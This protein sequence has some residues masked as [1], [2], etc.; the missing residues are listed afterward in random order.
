MDTKGEKL[1]LKEYLPEII[2]TGSGKQC[3]LSYYADDLYISVSYQT[4]QTNNAK[5]E[6]SFTFPRFISKSEETF[7]VL[8]LLQAEMGKTQNGCL[9]FTNSEPK[10]MNKV[11]KWFYKELDIKTEQWKWYLAA[12]IQKPQDLENKRR[13]EEY[14]AIYWTKNTPLLLANTH[15]TLVS[16]RDVEHLSLKSAYYGVM[17]IEFKNNLFSQIFKNVLRII[18][19]E[20][21]LQQ[22]I[23]FIRSFLK[24]LTAGEGCIECD[25]DSKKFRVHISCTIPAEKEIYIKCLAKLNINAYDYPG[26]KITVSRRENLVQLL[27]QRLMTLH[28]RKYAAFLNMMKHYPSISQQTGYFTGEK[29]VWNKHPEEINQ[30]ILKLFNQGITR[31]KDIAEQLEISTIKVNRILKKNNL[32]KR[33]IKTSETIRKE[34]ADY[35]QQH[36]ELSLKEIGEHF[37]LSE[38]AVVRACKKYN[39]KRDPGKLHCTIP[40]EKIQRIIQLYKDDPTIKFKQIMQEV[41]VSDTVI[42][43]VRKEHR[44]EH[45]GFKRLIGNNNKKYKQNVFKEPFSELAYVKEAEILL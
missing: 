23:N 16:Y 14:L 24:G 44:L 33:L 42:R 32:G 27:Q 17:I 37:N 30:N 25:K 1:D 40:E 6:Y 12:N 4:Q 15:P 29:K 11:L 7:E 39:V 41:G 3:V 8:G 28:P 22:E 10:I 34:L 18:T 21:L 13:I 20:K 35:A 45:L 38:S 2:L 9:N 36:T 19:Y 31:T 26:D 43:R 5:G